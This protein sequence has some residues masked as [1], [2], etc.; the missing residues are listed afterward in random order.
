[1]NPR[2][3]TIVRLGI[4]LLGPAMLVVLVWRLGDR[5]MLAAALANAAPLPLAAAVVLSIVPLHLKVWRWQALLRSCDQRYPLGRAY[6][7]VLASIYLGMVTPGRVGDVLRVQYARHEVGTPYS[8]GVATTV[9]DR[10]CDLYVLAAFVTLGIAHFASIL[11]GELVWPIWAMVAGSVLAP[12]LLLAPGIARRLF[13]RLHARLFP[14]HQEGFDRFLVA[15]RQQLG[16]ALLAALSLTVAA[17]AANYFQGWLIARSL[18]LELHLQDVMS[19]M[20]ITSLLGLMP[21]SISGLG[22]R[23]AFLAVVFPALGQSPA[24]GIA[25]GLL[26]FVALFLVYMIAG[27][28]AWQL[29]PPPTSAAV[30]P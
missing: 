28:V 25:F 2:S 18:G 15:M 19:V 13:G 10:C 7:A 4:R 17:F 27:F 22:V 8:I 30:S 16:P 9:M 23:E 20:A 21:I 3:R 5:D 24:Q 11:H 29:S 1:M 26:V 14:E 6:S 12:L